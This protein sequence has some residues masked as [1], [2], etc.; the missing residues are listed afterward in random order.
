MDNL[1]FSEEEIQEQLAILGYR[2][3][4][5]HTLREF[6][7]EPPTG[8]EVELEPEDTQHSPYTDSHTSTPD[9]ETHGRHFIKRKVLRKHKGEFFVCDESVHSEES[10]AASGLE[11]RLGGL[12]V[13]MS[14][15]HDSETENDDVTSQSEDHSSEND[16][17]S[18]SAFQ[19]YIRAMVHSG[20]DAGPQAPTQVLYFQYKREWDKF[21]VPGEQD[22]RHLRREVRERLASQPPP[23]K[24]QRVYVP[25]TYVVPTEKKRSALRWQVKHDLA[26]GL[27]PSR[28]DYQF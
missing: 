22:R 6:K 3:I 26:N 8:L 21:K 18:F 15:Q 19:S 24:P 10:D 14:T 27:L 16:G 7:R 9:G 11:E 12:H 25:N 20:P 1:D 2:N 28:F 17:I 13:S 23:P 4:P 5:K